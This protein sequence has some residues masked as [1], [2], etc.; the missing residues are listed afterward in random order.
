[1]IS[2]IH[3]SITITVLVFLNSSSFFANVLLG[4]TTGWE[5][6]VNMLEFKGLAGLVAESSCPIYLHTCVS[7][8]SISCYIHDKFQKQ[9]QQNCVHE[10]E[11]LA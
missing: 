11:M 4:I 2:L 1:M 6:G 7:L 3:F 8:L 10:N 5:N 9:S